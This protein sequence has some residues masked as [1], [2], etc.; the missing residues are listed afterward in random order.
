MPV[1]KAH[2]TDTPG[3]G[4]LMWPSAYRA[5]QGIY[6]NIIK[7]VTVQL[8][9]EK[10]VSCVNKILLNILCDSFYITLN[11]SPAM[12]QYSVLELINIFFSIPIYRTHLFFSSPHGWQNWTPVLRKDFQVLHIRFEEPAK[13]VVEA[14]YR[15]CWVVDGYQRSPRELVMYLELSDVIPEWKTNFAYGWDGNR[16][17]R[18]AITILHL[19]MKLF[20]TVSHSPELHA[21]GLKQVLMT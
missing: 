12:W 21:A 14:L 16:C 18:T 5:K 2:H 11:Y 8:S 6:K 17:L 15:S 19:Q 4:G 10:G 1:K 7:S 20:L 13:Q 3:A 9:N